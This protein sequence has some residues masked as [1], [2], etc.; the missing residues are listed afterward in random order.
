MPILILFR[1]T[2]NILKRI[3]VPASGRGGGGEKMRGLLPHTPNLGH[4]WDGRCFCLWKFSFF[5]AS[6]FVLLL[7]FLILIVAYYLN[8]LLHSS[9]SQANKMVNQKKLTR[10]RTTTTTLSTMSST[11]TTSSKENVLW[12][13]SYSIHPPKTKTLWLLFWQGVRTFSQGG[14]PGRRAIVSD[15]KMMTTMMKYEW[16]CGPKKV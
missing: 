3:F 10:S 1:Y 9:T 2:F 14:R 15:E 7:P 11:R 4:C 5:N 13:M 12:Q 16:K 8:S 6:L